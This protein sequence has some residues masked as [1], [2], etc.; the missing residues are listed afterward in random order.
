MDPK[1]K[2]R[3]IELEAALQTATN[4][5]VQLTDRYNRLSVDHAVLLQQSVAGEEDTDLHL[6]ALKNT[7]EELILFIQKVAD[8]SSKFAK[9]AKRLLGQ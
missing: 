7:N 5:V 6:N 8:S 4:Q 9:E 3:I 2:A 1:A